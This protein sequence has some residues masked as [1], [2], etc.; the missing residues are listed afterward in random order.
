[1]I[2]RLGNLVP[3]R[4]HRGSIDRCVRAARGELTEATAAVF[5]YG[6]FRLAVPALLGAPAFVILRRKLDRADRPALAC[7]PL[8]LDAVKLQAQT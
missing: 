3:V 1:M 8:A 2:G 5:V 4:W 7:A 6:V